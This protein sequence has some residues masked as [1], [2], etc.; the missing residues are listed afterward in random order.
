MKKKKIYILAC[1][2]KGFLVNIPVFPNHLFMEAAW[3]K[4]LKSTEFVF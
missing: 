1:N 3:K 2:E 4:G